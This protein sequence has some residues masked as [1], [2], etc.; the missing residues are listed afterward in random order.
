MA[1]ILIVSA[2]NCYFGLADIVVED[3]IRRSLSEDAS[4]RETVKEEKKNKIAHL[5]I[6]LKM[7]WD[8]FRS[9]ASYLVSM[10]SIG[11]LRFCV[12]IIAGNA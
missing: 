7:V 9:D 10:F 1:T 4:V 12:V 6:L 2:I 3:Q 8:E 11:L 5:R